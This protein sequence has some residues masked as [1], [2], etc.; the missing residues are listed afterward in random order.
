MFANETPLHNP[1]PM[2][3]PRYIDQEANVEPIDINKIRQFIVSK[4]THQNDKADVKK[5]YLKFNKKSITT[6]QY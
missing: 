3:I 6:R 2:C 1:L 5:N 4:N